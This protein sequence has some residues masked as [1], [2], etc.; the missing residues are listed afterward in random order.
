MQW[1]QKRV[2]LRKIEVVKCFSI[3]YY[4]FY[5]L[6]SNVLH[7]LLIHIFLGPLCKWKFI[8]TIIKFYFISFPSSL[9]NYSNMRIDEK[10]DWDV[11]LK[12]PCWGQYPYLPS[13]GTSKKKKA[14]QP[15][16]AILFGPKE[17]VDQGCTS[18]KGLRYL[19]GSYHQRMLQRDWD[20]WTTLVIQWIL[21]FPF[22]QNYSCWGLD[23]SDI[24]NKELLLAFWHCDQHWG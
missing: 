20:I 13:Q 18:L 24:S 22:L 2:E 23:D 4:N 21:E 19:E 3:M 11:H 9:L 7:P 15:F 12:K 16:Q 14:W 5:L 8:F 1:F 10:N 17:Y 6:F